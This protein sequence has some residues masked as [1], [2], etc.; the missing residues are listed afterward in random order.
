M[1]DAPL[2][3]G[4]QELMSCGLL[5]GLRRKSSRPWLS[6]AAGSPDTRAS[7]MSCCDPALLMRIFPDPGRSY[8]GAPRS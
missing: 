8:C 5:G 6:T 2:R 1:S 3:A 7:S 4:Q